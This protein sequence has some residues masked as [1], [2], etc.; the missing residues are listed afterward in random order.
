MGAMF[1]GCSSHDA[2][3]LTMLDTSS[4]QIMIAL[5]SGC[6]SLR[7]LNISNLNTSS[8][9][10]MGG[11]FFDCSSLK[12]VDVSSLNTARVWNMTALFANCTSLRQLDISN[13]DTTILADPNISLDDFWASLPIQVPVFEAQRIVIPISKADQIEYPDE[14]PDELAIDPIPVF[15]PDVVID[16]PAI[17]LS[18]WRK[19]GGMTGMF[20]NCSSLERITLGTAT[21]PIDYL[22]AF[23]IYGHIDWY[24]T[25][26]KKWFNVDQIDNDRLGIH[27][28]YVKHAD[29]SFNLGVIDLGSR[30]KTSRAP[31]A[32]T[33][34]GSESFG[35]I[36]STA[37]GATILMLAGARLRRRD[38]TA[39]DEPTK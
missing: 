19:V 18:Q 31:L 33:A 36:A 25:N 27:D 14:T 5:F 32:R 21:K 39:E 34:D 12:S 7:A 9:E 29:A 26:D 20:A 28:T 8:C 1:M 22:P 17:D 23:P 35:Q 38:A 37:L 10:D 15:V 3:D 6:S 4:A 11:M 13:F 2:L 24:S 30:Q 16:L